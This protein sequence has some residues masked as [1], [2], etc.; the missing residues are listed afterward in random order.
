MTISTKTEDGVAIVTIDCPDKKNAVTQEMRVMLGD[1]FLRLQ[2]DQTV[3]AIVLTG[4]G[5]DF[6]AGADASG[7][8]GSDIPTSM[9]R[10]RQLHRTMA[11]I[12]GTNKPV[13]AAVSGVC[14]GAGWSLALASDFII[15]AEDARFQMGFRHLGLAPDAGAAWLLTRY[16]GL[17][18]AKNIVYSGRFVN[19]HQA[20][21]LGLALETLPHPQVLP[22]AV[23]IASDY[24]K[25]ATLSLVMSKRLFDAAGAQ[26][27]EQA[28]AF[29]AN[30]QPL[31]TRTQD[32][33]EGIAAYR[34]KR[35]PNFTGA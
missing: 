18:Q 31:M 4:A 6:C 22:R 27:F 33:A 2:D 15:A 16:V 34:D 23:D 21:A 14:I 30:I 12:A 26:T 11:A 28:L 25:A 19:G 24:A 10:L 32:N 7:I 5:S 20:A 1:A 3:R 35:K 29:E 8:G 13:I 9:T 17:M